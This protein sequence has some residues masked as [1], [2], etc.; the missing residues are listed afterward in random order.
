MWVTLA[1]RQHH[2]YE[3]GGSLGQGE[4]HLD[5]PHVMSASKAKNVRPSR[6][7]LRQRRELGCRKIA[8]RAEL[9]AVVD[10]WQVVRITHCPF[11]LEIVHQ[12]V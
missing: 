4:V 2:N 6:G 8:G 12:L 5:L 11:R 10:R 9:V 3:I 1:R 7:V